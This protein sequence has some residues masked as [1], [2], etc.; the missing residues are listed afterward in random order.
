VASLT[1]I[2]SVFS[3]LIPIL[4]DAPADPSRTLPIFRVAAERVGEVGGAGT[5]GG[6]GCVGEPVGAKSVPESITIVDSFVT[7]SST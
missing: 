6:S 7:V 3:E 4:R 5:V 2:Q 1:V